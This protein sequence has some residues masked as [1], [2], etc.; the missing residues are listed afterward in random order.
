M[1]PKNLRSGSQTGNVDQQNPTETKNPGNLS[2]IDLTQ[3]HQNTNKKNILANARNFWTPSTNCATRG[4][5]PAITANGPETEHMA[6]ND[7]S[8][9]LGSTSYPETSLFKILWRGEANGVTFADWN[10]SK[11]IQLKSKQLP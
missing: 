11:R 7:A 4:S 3:P 5:P 9:F 2:E 8:T 1:P 10:V 6:T